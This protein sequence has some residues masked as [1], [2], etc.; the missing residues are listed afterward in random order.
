MKANHSPELRKTNLLNFDH[1]TTDQLK[2]RNWNNDDWRHSIIVL[3]LK[4][5]VAT[6]LSVAISWQLNAALY[7]CGVHNFIN[8][9]HYC[10]KRP[11]QPRAV[12]FAWALVS[13]P[14]RWAWYLAWELDL[15]A[16][17]RTKFNHRVLWMAFIDQGEFEAIKTLSGRRAPRCDK[18]QFRAKMTVST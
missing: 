2:H 4:L 6:L 10:G 16:R 14:D 18:D 11:C 7:L 15:C 8:L 3:T 12:N 17:M 13:F 1:M 5:W 9:A